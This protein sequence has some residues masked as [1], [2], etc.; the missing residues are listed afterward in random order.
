MNVFDQI[1]KAGNRPISTTPNRIT[2]ADGFS[3]SV[4]AGPGVYCTPRPALLDGLPD[5]LVSNAPKDFP[6]PYTAVEVGYP[7]ERPEPWGEWIQRCEDEERPTDTVYGY[8]P[9][10]MVRALIESHGGEINTEGTAR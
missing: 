3:L 4:I 8:V 1:V 5:G 7:S 2:C 10:D 9:V 6:G